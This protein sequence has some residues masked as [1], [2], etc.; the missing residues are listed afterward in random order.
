MSSDW[1]VFFCGGSGKGSFSIMGNNSKLVIA[2]DNR[3]KVDSFI[4]RVEHFRDE[5]FGRDRTI[6][7][8]M[9]MPN[10]ESEKAEFII[11][12]G[13]FGRAEFQSRNEI[14]NFINQLVECRDK[15][16]GVEIA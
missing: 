12:C 15:V 9:G 10:S 4:E 11:R 14:D 5:A 1:P 8:C 6:T 2:F 16:Y 13:G 7:L 3:D